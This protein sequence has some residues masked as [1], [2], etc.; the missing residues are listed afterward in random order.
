M[1]VSTHTH[2]HIYIQ[3]HKHTF[4]DVCCYKCCLFLCSDFCDLTLDP[5]TANK[6]LILSEDNRK[7]T[8]VEENQAYPDH[9]ERFERLPQVLSRESLSGRCYWEAEW[10][11]QADMSVAYKG[12]SRKGKSA[13]CWFGFNN[14]SWCL[15]CFNDTFCVWYNYNATDTHVPLSSSNRIG[16]YVDVS[17]GILSFYNVSDTHKLTHIHTFNNTFTEPLY[18]GFGLIAYAFNSTV[19]LCQ[20][21]NPVGNNTDVTCTRE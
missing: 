12:I 17:S 13:D 2:T 8:Y 3:I 7:V 21:E 9:P 4:S 15:V 16:M 10:S 11:G 19:S 14:N 6:N 20:S 1:Y 5:I 18:A